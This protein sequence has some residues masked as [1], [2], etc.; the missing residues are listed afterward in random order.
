MYEL[1]NN[2]ISQQLLQPVLAP[3]LRLGT[4]INSLS[5]WGNSFLLQ[6]EFM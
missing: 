2:D 4:I 1:D 6:M 3:F 5:C